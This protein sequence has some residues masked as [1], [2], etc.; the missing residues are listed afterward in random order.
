MN[1]AQLRRD[2]ESATL[3]RME[4]TRTQLLAANVGLRMSEHA[5]KRGDNALTLWNIGRALS[6]A[7][8]VT[9]LGSVL[10]GSLLVGPRHVVPLVLRKGLTGLIT[11][12]VRALVGR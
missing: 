10:F 11:R 12:N 6:A 8:S 4:A 1:R 3:T 2:L 5:S 9:L 7:P